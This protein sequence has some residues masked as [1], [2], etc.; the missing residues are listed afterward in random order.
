[1]SFFGAIGYIMEGSGLKEMLE[2][3][4]GENTV[5]HIFSGKA[6]ARAVRAHELV[7]ASLNISLLCMAYSI[8][9]GERPS[10]HEDLVRVSSV[11]DD[12]VDGKIPVEEAANHEALQPVSLHLEAL[13]SS[14]KSS[15][16]AKLFMQHSEMVS[17]F[18]KFL[19]A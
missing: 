3:V 17:I 9:Y 14:L 6:V 8:P 2:L 4:Y 11:Y 5:K 10:D 18:R 16:T 15:R 19:K 12:L 7:N 13:K 1:M